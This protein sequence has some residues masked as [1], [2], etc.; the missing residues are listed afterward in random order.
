MSGI[1]EKYVNELLVGAKENQSSQ[2][3]EELIKPLGT[4]T[5]DLGIYVKNLITGGDKKAFKNVDEIFSNPS[6][7]SGDP[8]A[9]LK[10]SFNR[11]FTTD[12][13]SNLESYILNG[14]AQIAKDIN[15]N[16]MVFFPNGS[17]G[18]HNEPGIS[19]ADITQ[20]LGSAVTW[21]GAG[22]VNAAI[23]KALNLPLTNYRFLTMQ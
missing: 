22:R 16:I 14:N 10:M 13:V 23:N 12:T 2:I 8:L 18:Y 20:I 21:S 17:Y 15:D 19:K 4:K 3:Y 1:Q 7:S 5:I 11:M 6:I 9:D